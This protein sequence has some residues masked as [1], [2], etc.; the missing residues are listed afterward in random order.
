MSFFAFARENPCKGSIEHVKTHCKYP[1]SAWLLKA[2]TKNAIVEM[3]KN[4]FFSFFPI[5]LIWHDGIW[6]KGT[7][8]KGYWLKGT[9]HNGTWHNGTWY[10]G[11]W[12][13]DYWKNGIWHDG[14]W[15]NGTWING[16][17]K[18]KEANYKN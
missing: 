15:E 12:K 13:Q 8:E 14:V 16:R 10:D 17:N 18:P 5:I 6:E 4:S 2:E 11:I 7:W 9:W 1:L 3:Y